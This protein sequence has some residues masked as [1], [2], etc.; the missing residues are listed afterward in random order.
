MPRLK[1][2]SRLAG[3]ESEV[4]HERVGARVR[5]ERLTAALL[6]RRHRWSVPRVH[7]G[8]RCGRRRQRL[9]RHG[10]LPQSQDALLHQPLHRQPRLRRPPRH[11][12]LPPLHPRQQRHVR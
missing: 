12:R 4:E 6:G 5:R 2:S 11:R 1:L 7:A 10:R 3:L 8:V 9:R